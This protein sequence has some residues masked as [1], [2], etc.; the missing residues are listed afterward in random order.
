[1]DAAPDPFV[2]RALHNAQI[3]VPL[4]AYEECAVREW[5]SSFIQKESQWQQLT[6]VPT[7]SVDASLNSTKSCLSL[8]QPSSN[9]RC[10]KKAYPFP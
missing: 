10:G 4:T 9:Q 3:G 5:I 8:L 1:M 7:K 6:Q 2:Q